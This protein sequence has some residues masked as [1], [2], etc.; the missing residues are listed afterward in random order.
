VCRLEQL[1]SDLGIDAWYGS[2]GTCPQEKAVVAEIQVDLSIDRRSA[3]QLDLSSR[4]GELDRTDE[5]SR[6]SCGEEPLSGWMRLREPDIE[7]S[8]PCLVRIAMIVRP[9]WDAARNP[10]SGGMYVK[11]RID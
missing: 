8:V 2:V 6:P 7:T 11:L 5:A 10:E 4:G 1:T 3:W 9:R